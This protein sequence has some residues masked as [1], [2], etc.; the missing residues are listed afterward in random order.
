V[1]YIQWEL[2][3]QRQ[4]L[5]A[6]LLGTATTWGADETPAGRRSAPRSAATENDLAERLLDSARSGGVP[7]AAVRGSLPETAE[8]T[9]RRVYEAGGTGPFLHGRMGRA[10]QAVHMN[11]TSLTNQDMLPQMS[12]VGGTAA[13]EGENWWISSGA[14]VAPALSAAGSA[15]TLSRVIQRDARRYDGG[16]P[17]Y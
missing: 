1:D 4:A 15:G 12:Y 13:G 10:D 8:E 16:F 17:L 7:S 6:L 11:R 5:E 9:V 3:R 14:P 2:E